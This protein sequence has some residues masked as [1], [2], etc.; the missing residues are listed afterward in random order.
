MRFKGDSHIVLVGCKIGLSCESSEI[1]DKPTGHVNSSVWARMSHCP[2]CPVVDRDTCSK[3]WAI[4][5]TQESWLTREQILSL[6]LGQLA[7]VL[8]TGTIPKTYSQCSNFSSHWC[9]E[10]TTEQ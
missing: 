3:W 7:S 9:G 1:L 4:S 10:H 6:L 5:S 8:I 2:N